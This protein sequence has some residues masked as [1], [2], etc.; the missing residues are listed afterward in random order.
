[1]IRRVPTK[2]CSNFTET[3]TKV[4]PYLYVGDIDISLKEKVPRSTSTSPLEFHEIYTREREEEEVHL[5]EP[6][7][8]PGSLKMSE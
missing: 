4:F 6:H 1:M 3:S 8:L 5:Q 2:G 7:F